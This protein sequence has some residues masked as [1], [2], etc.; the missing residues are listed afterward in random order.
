MMKVT[1]S[2]SVKKYF[3]TTITFFLVR[4]ALEVYRC[5]SGGDIVILI[6]IFSPIVMTISPPKYQYASRLLE[7]FELKCDYIFAFSQIMWY[8]SCLKQ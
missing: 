6:G 3:T 5:H 7:K 4:G 2:K 1:V 8:N